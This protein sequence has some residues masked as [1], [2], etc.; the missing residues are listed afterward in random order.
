MNADGTYT[1]FN[2]PPGTTFPAGIFGPGIPATDVFMGL[3]THESY[4]V[5]LQGTL[6]VFTGGR[7]VSGLAVAYLS[8]DIAG[9]QYRKAVNDTLYNVRVAFYSILLA[10][11]VVTIRTE[12]LD[13]L[14]RHL[15]TTRLKYDVGVVSR[16]D[17]LR[18]EVEVANARPPLISARKDLVLAGE[19]LKRVMGV[20]VSEPFEIEGELTFAEEAV[21][22]DGLLKEADEAS[23]ELIIARKA[24]R[25]ASKNVKMA[26]G[27]FLPMITTFARYEG[28]IYDDISWEQDDWAVG[29]DGGRD[30][31]HADYG[32]AGD[33]R[34]GQGGPGRIHEGARGGAGHGQ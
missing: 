13:L 24:E 5:G 7:V 21:D 34:K 4:N 11:E 3:P 16:F 26:F 10:R 8:D 23:P 6:P 33:G 28:T 1:Y 20:D 19:T 31:V 9:E 30:G 18:S 2:T 22:L 12:A 27:E 32:P 17:V 29:L 14:T 25:I 15:E